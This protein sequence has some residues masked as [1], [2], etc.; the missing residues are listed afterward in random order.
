MRKTLISLMTV[1]IALAVGVLAIALTSSSPREALKY[2]FTGPFLNAYFFGNMITRAIP[3]ILTGLAASI[4]FSASAF[5]LGLE[6]QVYFGAIAGTLLGLTMGSV[7]VWLTCVTIM[8][9]SFAV[10]GGIAA[11]SGYLKA[12]WKVNELISS[13]LVSYTLIN[14]GDALLEGPFRDPRAGLA[15]SSYMDSAIRFPRILMPSNLH[16][17][18][19][20]VLAIAVFV[21]LAIRFSRLGYEIRITG[22]NISFGAYAGIHVRKVVI[23]AMAISGALAGLAGMVDVLGVHGRVIRGF[24]SGYGWNGI[25][26]A[27]IA[28][29]N[30]ILVIPA[31]LFFAFLTSGAEVSSFFTDMSPEIARI[32]Q[33]SIFY[34]VTAEGLLT[35]LKKRREATS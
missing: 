17:G 18:L 5:N 1:A 6:G 8:I 11:I 9:V 13:L 2:F 29:R 33:A 3:L 27:L 26:V 34:L 14:I 35:F 21:F 22:S 16:A 25:A 19:F 20:L 4:A 7:P 23:L 28:R 12:K 30:P 24:S 10:G 15:A 31:A 32:I